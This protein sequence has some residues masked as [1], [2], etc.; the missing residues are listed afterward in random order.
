MMKLTLQ[1]SAAVVEKVRAEFGNDVAD[2][3]TEL[4][5][6]APASG[7]TNRMLSRKFMAD[8]LGISL[9]NFDRIC[10]RG[11]GPPLV[12][13]SPR[14]KGCPEREYR[15]WREQLRAQTA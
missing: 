8:D 15:Q 11:A 1:S 3:L 13:I 14:R 2:E 10:A 7:H 4:L 5:K 6:S 12:Q 9:D